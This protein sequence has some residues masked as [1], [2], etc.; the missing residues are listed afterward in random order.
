[1]KKVIELSV[2]KYA[3]QESRDVMEDLWET[4]GTATIK[5]IGSYLALPEGVLRRY[6]VEIEK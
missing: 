4:N 2:S 1:M 5:V 6:E 3:D